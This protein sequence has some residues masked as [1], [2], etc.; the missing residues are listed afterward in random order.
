MDIT[1]SGISTDNKI[2]GSRATH[3]YHERPKPA[4]YPATRGEDLAV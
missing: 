4:K 1:I 2:R 3:L